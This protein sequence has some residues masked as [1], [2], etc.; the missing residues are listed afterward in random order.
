MKC[1]DD[2]TEVLNLI[3]AATLKRDI[4]KK[5]N[6][7]CQFCHTFIITSRLL[8]IFRHLQDKVYIIQ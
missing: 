7:N 6:N 1:E 3:E 5:V 8:S 4:G 2:E